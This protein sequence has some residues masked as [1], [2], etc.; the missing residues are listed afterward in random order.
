M[1]SLFE[2]QLQTQINSLDAMANDS[3]WFGQQLEAQIASLEHIIQLDKHARELKEKLVGTRTLAEK[4]V[5]EKKLLEVQKK[6]RS[7]KFDTGHPE[8]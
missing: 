8:V 7:W 5:V 6:Q 2:Q 3:D 1:A 4:A